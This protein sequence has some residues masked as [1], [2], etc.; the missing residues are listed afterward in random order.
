MKQ[1]SGSAALDF[2]EGWLAVVNLVDGG[3][4]TAASLR[5]PRLWSHGVALM[6]ML[7]VVWVMLAPI[8]RVVR[9]DGKVVPSGKNRVVQHLEGGVVS[10]IHVK[11]G[12]AVKAGETLVDISA[13]EADSDLKERAIKVSGLKA[14]AAR[15]LAEANGS[16]MAGEPEPGADAAAWS[17]EL[18]NFTGRKHRLQQQQAVYVEQLN[19]RQSEISELGVRGANLRAELATAQRQLETHET[20]LAKRAASELDVLEARSRQQRIVTQLSEVEQRVPQL[21]GAVREIQSKMQSDMAT[22]RAEARTELAAVSTEARSIEEE[23][24]ARGER[25][26]RTTIVSPVDGVINRL[27]VSSVGT[28]VRPGEPVAEVTPSGG[29]MVIEGQVQPSDRAEL[30]PGLPAIIKLGPY[31]YTLHGTL[32]AEIEDISADALSDDKGRTFYRVRLKVSESSIK[33][34]NKP[35]VPGMPLTADVVLSKRTVGSYI[36]SSVLRFGST[37]LRDAR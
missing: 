24:R 7:I 9:S 28:V 29:D 18:L 5:R 30:R 4:A 20:L 3:L 37:A 27:F 35:I 11:E 1:T 25:L 23:I 31:D 19:Q 32:S 6:T 16:E 26:K 14:R 12:V 8:E 33:A 17:L 13:V 15:L 22:F 36:A 10:R 34:F 21:R 2:P